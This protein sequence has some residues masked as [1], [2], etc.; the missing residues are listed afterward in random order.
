MKTRKKTSLIWNIE[1]DKLLEIVN[2]SKFLKNV[3]LSLG[4]KPAGSTFR[5][6]KER[7][8]LENINY[9]HFK[10]N[11]NNLKKNIKLKKSTPLDKILISNKKY[12]RTSLKQRLIKEN[13]IKNECSFCG[14]RNIWNNKPIVLQL[15]HI[16]GINDDNR[17]EN[18]RLLCPNC[19][20][21]TEHF[22]GR[23]TKRFRNKKVKNGNSPEQRI[24]RRKV[25]N[26]PSKD[27][28]EKD[29]K[30]LGYCGTGR[31]YGVSDNAIRK[32]IK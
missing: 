19:H 18:L 20:T 16:N 4:Y 13:R 26:R 28:L 2:K 9:S 3:L 17:I 22:A 10:E 23:N 30:E 7:L 31:K 15:D 27:I 12:N 32:W 5:A 8:K 11:F 21:Q 24:L 1:K 14:L 29:I 25:I 6:L